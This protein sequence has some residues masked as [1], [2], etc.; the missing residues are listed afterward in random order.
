MFSV[1]KIT[2]RDQSLCP[3]YGVRVAICGGFQA[4]SNTGSSVGL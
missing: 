3:L 1:L 2:V 4:V